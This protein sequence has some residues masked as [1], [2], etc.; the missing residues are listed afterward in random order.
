MRDYKKGLE[1]S[2]AC[3]SIMFFAVKSWNFVGLICLSFAGFFLDFFLRTVQL[4]WQVPAPQ[5]LWW[6]NDFNKRSFNL[7][8][9]SIL[10]TV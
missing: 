3:L 9:V 10:L 6:R 5:P 7:L 2:V 4:A 1:L 8:F